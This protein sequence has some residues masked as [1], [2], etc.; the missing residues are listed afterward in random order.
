MESMIEV[1][2]DYKRKREGRGYATTIISFALAVLVFMLSVTGGVYLATRKTVCRLSDQP[3]SIPT[4]YLASN[5]NTSV[6]GISGYIRYD[7]GVLDRANPNKRYMLFELKEVETIDLSDKT[8]LRLWSGCGVIELS[9][10]FDHLMNTSRLENAQVSLDQDIFYTNTCYLKNINWN[11]PRQMHYACD[12]I[13]TYDCTQNGKLVASLTL[14]HIE[15]EIYSQTQKIEEGR[16][17]SEP[18]YC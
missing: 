11:A 9:F 2:H 5:D 18:I 6:V 13:K 10:Q 14:E 1:D 8:L 7:E 4:R 16:F 12:K 17:S 15:L 3:Q